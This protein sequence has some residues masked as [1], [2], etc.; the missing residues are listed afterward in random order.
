M[1]IVEIS[2]GKHNAWVDI[3]REV[4]RVVASQRGE[5]WG[6]GGVELAYDGWGDG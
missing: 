5:E 6:C 1:E 4:Q 3:T 2:T